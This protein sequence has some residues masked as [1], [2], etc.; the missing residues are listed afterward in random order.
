MEFNISD[1]LD[2]L[3]EVP[4]DIHPKPGASAKRIK[5]LTMKKI[6]TETKPRHRTLS[7]F[8][9]ILIAAA[10]LASLAIPV[11][12]ATGF[13]F[14]DWL[15]GLDRENPE[16]YQEQYNSWEQTEGFWQISLRAQDLTSEGMTLVCK[17]V[18]D[19]PISGTLEVLGGY[20]LEKWNGEAF[21]QMQTKTAV[22][23]EEN[24]MIADGESFE[25]DINWKNVYG[26]LES[27]RYRLQKNFIY[28]FTDG[29][30]AELKEW[31]EFRIFNE[32]MTPYIAQCKEAMETLLNAENSHVEVTVYYYDMDDV[33]VNGVDIHETWRSGDNYLLRH[34]MSDGGDKN[35]VC[36]GEMLLGDEGYEIVRWNS[37]DIM[38]GAAEWEYDELISAELNRFDEWHYRFGMSETQV[39]EIWVEGNE[40]VVL[41]KYHVDGSG[42]VYKENTYC[43][44]ND[45]NLIG[46]EI[47]YLPGPWC[48]EEEKR[49]NAVLTV[50]DISAEEAAQVIAAQ[51]VTQLDS[52]SWSAEQTEHI[53]SGVGV[54]TSGFVNTVPCKIE[55]GYDAFMRAFN[56]YE[57]VAHH[58]SHVAYDRN[59]D[60]WRVEFWWKNGDINSV[61]YL[62]G[63]GITQMTVTGPYEDDK[64]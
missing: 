32:D 2:D 43:F 7:A 34:T 12:A 29:K 14:T 49:L 38:S 16:E 37:E 6:H 51:D 23:P 36:F 3:R 18:Q 21:V 9:K 47:N 30:T 8:S 24:R 4:V 55:S 31:A 5:E 1:L 48:T 45:G 52:F 50:H 61:I 26:S 53:S 41:E 15:K 20:S 63:D 11:M 57:A 35:R 40:I 58:A 60:M 42:D 56:D 27:G 59:A 33:T 19:T 44:D 25:T 13:R 46:G 22:S 64:Q 54:K 39:G 17:E 28:T 10:V 62:N